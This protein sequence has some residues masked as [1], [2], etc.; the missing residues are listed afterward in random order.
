MGTFY[1][2]MKVNGLD[3]SPNYAGSVMAIVNGIG[4]LTGII[5]PYIVGILTPDVS[6][7]YS[8]Y[9]ICICVSNIINNSLRCYLFGLDTEKC[10]NS[11]PCRFFNLYN[12]RCK[13][14]ETGKMMYI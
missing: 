8:Y 3:L 5:V 13:V 14:K 7:Y 11:R 12:E 4:A 10:N 9:F 1:A 2:G 6:H